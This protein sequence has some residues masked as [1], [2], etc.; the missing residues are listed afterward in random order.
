MCYTKTSVKGWLSILILSV[1]SACE[2]DSQLSSPPELPEQELAVE[3]ELSDSVRYR[4]GNLIYEETMEGVNPFA[5][6]YV[7]RQLPGNHSFRTVTSLMLEGQKSGR[8]ELRKGDPIVTNSGIR[9]EMSFR[10]QLLD[11]LNLEGWYSFAVYLPSDEFTPDDDDETLSQ[12]HTA[13]SPYLSLRVSNDRFKFRIGKE[14][15]DLGPAV[16]DFWHQYVFHIKHSMGSNGLIEVWQNGEKVISKTGPSSNSL[17]QPKWKIGIYKPTWENRSTNTSKRVLYYD[18][19]KIGNRNASY[20]DMLPSRAKVSDPMESLKAG[21][22]DLDKGLV[23]HWKMDEGSGGVLLDHSGTNN[24]ARIVDPSGIKWVNGKF[25]SAIRMPNSR[26]RYFSTVSHNNSLNLTEAVTISAWIRPNQI[27][28]RTILS[29]IPNG[30]E[31]G[32]FENGKIEFRINRESDGAT[33]RL[34]SNKSY[35]TDGK[36]WMHVVATFD[37][38]STILYVNG[39]PDNSAGYGPTQIRTN[40]EPLTIGARGTIY[41]WEG[42]LDDVRVYNRAVTRAE[43]S[44]L[45]GNNVPSTGG[46]SSIKEPSYP[47]TPSSP[48]TSAPSPSVPEDIGSG[49]VGFWKMNEGSGRTLVD[50][51]G[52]RNNANIVDV[53]GVSWVKGR[54]GFALRMDEPR[55]RYF[56]TVPHNSTL[57]MSNAVTISAWIRPGIKANRMIVSKAPNGFELGTFENGKIEFRINRESDGSKYRLRSKK[58]YPTDGNTWI[59]VAA[60]FDGTRSTIYINGV[61]DNSANYSKTQIKTNTK[62]LVIGARDLGYRWEGDLDNVMIYNRALSA[63]EIF[64]LAQ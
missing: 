57:N 64:N 19:V 5:S 63:N 21:P 15:I 41:R 29:K 30:Y 7:S 20:E 4:L 40:R 49:L 23:G 53:S 51:S 47:S 34:R 55:G 32:I 46:S 37:G 39:V 3:E 36:T 6:L 43:A 54:D 59:H 38:R 16:K 12:W 11:Q 2:M 61:A 62:P 50:H 18:N 17:I 44:A 31:L 48:I 58:S 24:D 26:G 13:G 8:F 27:G 33:Y 42:D 1:V 25:G 28:T 52:N 56:S 9:S 45:F 60:T 22:V 10:P 35:P 14:Y